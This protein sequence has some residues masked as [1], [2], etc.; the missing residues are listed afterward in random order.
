[1]TADA[2][3]PITTELEREKLRSEIAELKHGWRK[4]LLTA[5]ITVSIA[6]GGWLLQTHQD[7]AKIDAAQANA[8]T[9]KYLRAR[10]ALSSAPAA[11]G[12][13]I[14][15]RD[16]GTFLHRPAPSGGGKYEEILA[17]LE[18]RLLSEND[19]D[20]LRTIATILGNSG[21]PALEQT[22]DQNRIAATRLA[23][24]YGEYVGATLND[25]TREQVKTRNYMSLMQHVPALIDLDRKVADSVSTIEGGNAAIAGRVIASQIVSREYTWQLFSDSMQQSVPAGSQTTQQE[26]VAAARHYMQALAATSI[27]LSGLLRQLSGTLQG[28]NLE[29][30]TLYAVNLN[31]D[32][33]DGAHLARS[34]LSGYA[35]NTTFKGADLRDANL[36]SLTLSNVDFTHAQLAGAVFNDL[37]ITT[38]VA[39]HSA[40]KGIFNDAD[41]WNA[42]VW[43][44][45]SNSF[46]VPSWMQTLFPKP[47]NA[48][49]LHTDCT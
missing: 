24:A 20:V 11:S 9:D 42:C 6:V 23:D 18:E 8:E 39:G 17:A 36:E 43:D 26:R 29:T 47:R 4:T 40:S 32:S 10:D 22:L 15:A 25:R 2:Q 44:P 37:R 48:V 45:A 7:R 30:M 16:L 27:A 46:R 28:K 33:L 31:Q 49:D 5:V 41:W 21:L 1:M 13:Q 38:S 19:A 34:Y 14:A 3:D 35:S 12:R